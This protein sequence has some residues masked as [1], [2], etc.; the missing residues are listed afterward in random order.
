MSR[1]FSRRQ[2]LGGLAGLAVVG[3]GA[4]GAYRYWLGKVAEAEA[5][6]GHD[7]EL[8]A[9]PLDVELVPGHKTQAWAFGSSAPGTELRVRQGEWL[10]VRFINHLPVATTIH[11]HGIRLPLEMDGVPYVSQLPVL[12]GE[13]F[14]YKFRVPDAGSYWYHPHVNS[15]EELGRGLVGPL[16]IEE[17][18]PTGF[19][20][21][22]TLSLKSWHVDE[23]GAFVA[24]SIPRE[25]ARGGTAGRLSTINGVSQAVIDLPAGQITRVR[26]L[27]LD[28]TLTYRLNIPDVEAQIYALDGN[29]IEPRPMGKEYWLGPGMRICLAIKAPPAGEELSIRNGPV[30]LGTF[31]SV[32]STDAPAQWP[33]ALPANPISEPDLANAEK[34]NFNFEW[35]GSVS[36]NVDNGKPPSLWQI[37]GKAWDI[38]DKT[39]A[40]RPIAKLEKG[41]SYIFELKNMTQYQ[42]PIHLHGMSFKVIAS[43]RH[44]VIPYFTDT[45][46][47]GKN[48]R[49]RVALVADNPGVWMFHCHVIDHMETGLMAAIEVA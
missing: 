6:A 41:K 48:E 14:D 2:I 46:L 21:E 35:V 3:V 15:S 44:K 40:D 37:N 13:Y 43:N 47:L 24:F 10:R 19:K 25:A 49:A 7:Y 42:H 33:P 23:E 22:R 5:E 32:A 31:R 30:R 17:R 36:V 38:T 4:G 18:E 28:N 39:C 9:A 1:S 26:L 45:Y 16:I 20:H 12:P 34:L 8:I 27:N 11:W 29:P